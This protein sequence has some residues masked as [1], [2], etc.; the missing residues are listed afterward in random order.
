MDSLAYLYS[1]L[2]YEDS[3]VSAFQL[4][5]RHFSNKIALWLL[6]I[7][8]TLAIGHLQSPVFAQFLYRTL[9]FGQSGSDVELVQ[10]CLLELGYFEGQITARFDERTRDAVRA[11][12]FANRDRLSVNDTVDQETAAFLLTGCP[13]VTQSAVRDRV[14][15]DRTPLPSIP[16]PPP[17]FT[18]SFDSILQ[19]G[20]EGPDVTRLQTLLTN[21]GFDTR[22]ID[23]VFGSNTQAALFDLQQAYGLPQT[24]SY[25]RATQQVLEGNR[26]TLPSTTTRTFRTLQP[27]DRG[28]EVFDLQTR[29]RDLGFD[30][31]P[32]D[33]IYGS[34]TQEAVRQY[35]LTFNIRPA[36]GI[37]SSE[38]IASLRRDEGFAEQPGRGPQRY[39]VVVPGRSNQRLIRVRAVVPQARIF[40]DRRGSYIYAGGYQNRNE[41]ESLSFLLK[42]RGLNARVDY[43]PDPVISLGFR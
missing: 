40:A 39:I 6:S 4:N 5:W 31:G 17:N 9:E 20:S 30:P 14:I 34:Q 33:S 24:G 8:T 38:T 22:G 26:L 2:A 16:P 19:I 18:G 29:L 10:R 41:A 7:L 28:V 25:D 43:M 35:Q 3:S 27:G 21:A 36:D 13:Q 32:I 37:A 11:F 42:A 15:I 1:A 12:K 23:G